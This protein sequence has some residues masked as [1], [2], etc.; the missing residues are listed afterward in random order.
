M[1]GKSYIIHAYS[2]KKDSR[3][4]S[5]IIVILLPLPNPLQPAQKETTLFKTYSNLPIPFL[6][7]LSVTVMAA[8]VL[9]AIQPT[10]AQVPV[11]A[12]STHWANATTDSSYTGTGA[13]GLAAIGLTGN[14]YTYQFGTNVSTTDN[15]QIL[16]SFTAAS[17]TFKYQPTTM[18]VQFRRVNNASVTGARKS[19]M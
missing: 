3:R 12:I 8:S 1:M 10:H 18:N 11:T 19:M 13:T 9:T 4:C 5:S 6:L 14:N 2:T 16:D 17:E 7:R 15:K